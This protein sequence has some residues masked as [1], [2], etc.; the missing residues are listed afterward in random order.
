V[1]ARLVR[2]KG[3]D[4]AMRTLVR[5]QRQWPEAHIKVLGDGPERSALIAQAASLGL[6]TSV[7]F[8]GHIPQRQLF[9]EM[10]AAEACLLLSHKPGER[11]PNAVKEAMACGSVPVVADCPGMSEL[12]TDGLNGRI[13]PPHDPEAAS[14]ALFD[15]L[16]N[17][18]RRDAMA[19]AAQATV[20]DR[21]SS[22]ASMGKYILLWRE[23]CAR[24]Q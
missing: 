6:G 7:Q 22:M 13:V 16:S 4:D 8:A 10:A 24:N 15:V 12:I 21:F 11:L 20:R 5:L 17:P 3:I 1:V 23:A 14:A 2:G 19:A 9:A 18:I